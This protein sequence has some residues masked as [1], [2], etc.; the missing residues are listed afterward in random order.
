VTGV[1][2]CAL[3]IWEGPERGNC[4]ALIAE[5]GLEG[6]VWLPGDR[7]DTPEWYRCFDLFALPSLGEGISNTILEAM[8][9]GLP[10]VATRVGGTPELVREGA[11]GNGAM[12]PSQD[13]EAM[14]QVLERM[15][16]DPVAR[17]QAGLASR[18]RIERDFIIAR[19]AVGY[20]AVYQALLAGPE[21]NSRQ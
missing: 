20:D 18:A 12:T 13:P 21:G 15:V 2:T 19:M 10:I 4:E 9:S 5:L 1:Q 16:A 7:N 6:Q 14:A 8:A 17:Q 3:P 11:D